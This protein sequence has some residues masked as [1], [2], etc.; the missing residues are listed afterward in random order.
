MDTENNIDGECHQ[1]GS[2]KVNRNEK[3]TYT[4]KDS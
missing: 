4:E 2:L 3:E 1:L